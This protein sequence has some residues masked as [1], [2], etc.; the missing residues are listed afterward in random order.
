MGLDDTNAVRS[1]GFG[2]LN[3]NVGIGT[4]TPN[5][6]LEVN[7]SLGGATGLRIGAPNMGSISINTGT[8]S[9]DNNFPGY[10]AWFNGTGTR[11]SYLG[12]DSATN[13]NW[14][15]E[16]GANLQISG[17]NVE[18]GGQIK[19]AGG[20][21][22]AGKVLT[23]DANG[24]ASW[25]APAAGGTT[26]FGTCDTTPF[27]P[28][29]TTG[30]Q[31]LNTSGTQ[32]IVVATAS[33]T[34]V[35]GQQWLQGFIGSASAGTLVAN[36][37]FLSPNTASITFVVPPGYY[38][39]VVNQATNGPTLNA[40]A[41]K[42][43]GGGGGSSSGGPTILGPL[44]DSS[45]DSHTQQ[46][47]F[48]LATA[49]NVLIEAHS[50]LGVPNSVGST[51]TLL[52]DGVSVDEAYISDAANSGGA[53]YSVAT[54]S[55]RMDLAAGSH[56]LKL[57]FPSP[58]S[59]YFPAGRPQHPTYFYVYML[60]PGSGLTSGFSGGSTAGVT[61]IV[62]G[63][64]VTISPAGGTGAVTINA[65]GSSSTGNVCGSAIY[66]G[67][68]DNFGKYTLTDAW[69]CVV[70]STGQN[71]Q[72]TTDSNTMTYLAAG[73]CSGGARKVTIDPLTKSFMCVY[74]GNIS[75][76]QT[77]APGA[78]CGVYNMEVRNSGTAFSTINACL[79]RTTDS[80][81]T[82]QSLCPTGFSPFSFGGSTAGSGIG[83]LDTLKV[84]CIKD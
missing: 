59:M 75:A 52:V 61:S 49:T 63:T 32:L 12:Y 60:T 19:I 76:A 23:S 11:L 70:D 34:S 1:L 31:Y 46:V 26:S 45:N 30:T 43:C 27:A 16:N 22:G 74:E 25:Q 51:A 20:A 82:S 71:F 42:V 24:L 48:S 44:A 54:L 13:M 80:T 68:I 64:G 29:M 15:L 56:T 67:K 39:K 58:G 3:G 57:T 40:N 53:T 6:K 55:V 47:T 18:L 79:G 73:T 65:S 9:T 5:A 69:G 35:S 83:R 41:W 77:F 37:V 17:G 10:L 7:T 4:L 21:P 81:S 84:S 78:W 50:N 36:D 8:L 2:V 28:N 33:E 14:K 38:Y 66:H 72:G 62:A